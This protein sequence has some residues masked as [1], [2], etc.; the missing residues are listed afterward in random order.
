[1]D[2]QMTAVERTRLRRESEESPTDV[3]P[4]IGPAAESALADE[5]ARIKVLM[6]PDATPGNPYQ[7]QLAAA[8]DHRGV[9]VALANPAGALPL[10][11]VVAEHAPINILH[12]HWTHRL[13]VANSRLKSVLKGVRFIME[14]AWLRW[15]GVRLVW[16]AHNLLE[17]EQR[18]PGI[19][20]FF[21]RLA[22]HLYHH[23]IVHCDQARRAVAETYRISPPRQPKLHT[24]P[25][26]HFLDSYPNAVGQTEARTRLGLDPAGLLLLHFGQIRPYKGVFELLDAF[27][28]LEAP[29]VA[30]LIAGR[31]WDEATAEALRVRAQR[32]P[33]IHLYLDFVPDEEVQIYLN[34]A[35][36]VV[37][38]YRGVL[39]SGSAM[40]AM[41]FGR[42]V[43]MP[44]SGCA[45]E[46][47]AGEHGALLYDATGDGDMSLKQAM[48][49][50]LC[51]DLASMGEHNRKRAECFGWDAIAWLT[52]RAYRGQ[53][54]P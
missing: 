15:R 42:A 25:H 53:R 26:G 27:E 51:R 33:R 16:T 47:L 21:G 10:L 8:L 5:Q 6:V 24:I 52:E 2:G 11:S 13:V 49:H 41:S 18:H 30:V 35:D 43:V 45:E 9:H 12:L 29:S 20:L 38:P 17:H 39:T 36:V 50:M 4:E 37:L 14:L 31:P 34:A 48:Q 54:A 28:S 7:R 44:R 1:M 40:L 22:E 19:E 46:M 3:T 23:I 32:N